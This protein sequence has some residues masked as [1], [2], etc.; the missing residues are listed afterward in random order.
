MDH[1]PFH[2]YQEKLP[3]KILNTEDEDSQSFSGQEEKYDSDEPIN[4]AVTPEPIIDHPITLENTPSKYSSHLPENGIPE[5]DEF[6]SSDS[7]SS[8]NGDRDLLIPDLDFLDAESDAY[9]LS[10]TKKLETN[11]PQILQ[12]RDR[13]KKAASA[14]RKR[15]K[16]KI[17]KLEETVKKL[18]KEGREYERQIQLT[19]DQ[20]KK[21]Q[22]M[23]KNHLPKCRL[24]ANAN[25][26]YK[27]AISQ[28]RQRTAVTLAKR[29]QTEVFAKPYPVSRR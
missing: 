29:Q 26:R 6:H 1:L 27:L 15:Q 19:K 17:E 12:R 4:L 20:I 25:Q 10:G 8:S 2:G 5:L 28:R 14:C 18:T 16:E 9:A 24:L 3:D 21:C 23:F 11:D 7:E 13:N 22:T